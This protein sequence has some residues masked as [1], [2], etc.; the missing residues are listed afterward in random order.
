MNLE[1][2]NIENIY[3]LSPLQQ[4]MLFHTLYAPQSGIYFEQFC[5]PIRGGIN[6]AALAQA[7]QQVINRHSI[8]RTSFFWENIEKPLQVVH[9]QVQLPIEQLDWRNLSPAEQEERLEDYLEAD[10]TKGFELSLAP[11]IRLALIR[12]S[13]DFYQYILS[14]HHL[15]LDGWSGHLVIQEVTAFYQAHCRGETLQLPPEEVYSEQQ[16]SLT[17]ATTTALQSLVRREKLTLNTLLQGAWSL[18]LGRYSGEADVV[19]GAVVSGRPAT[20][21]GIESMVGMFIN[22]LPVRIQISPEASLISW[23]QG[24]QAQQAET[25]KYEYAPLMQVLR[26]S[27]IPGDSTLFESVLVFENY[28]V[29]NSFGE[30]NGTRS[31][32]RV[33]AFERTNLPLS[34]FVSEFEEQLG[35]KLTYDCSRFDAATATRLLGHLRTILEGTATNSTQR[36]AE[37]PLLTTAECQQVLEEW[38]ETAAEYPREVCIHQLFEAR[39]ERRPEAV[40]LVFGEEQ[41]SYAELNRRA[42]QLAHY[43]QQQGVGV[44]TLVGVMVARSVELVVSLL[45]VLKAGA[46]YVPLDPGYPRERLKYMIEDAGIEVVVTQLGLEE[47]LGEQQIKVVRV[48]EQGSELG[49]QSV[50]NVRSGATAENLA[51]VIYTS[52]STGKP[53]GALGTHRAA[54]N[55]FSWMWRTYPF[56]RDEICCQK[57]ST[58]FVDSIWEIFGPLLQGVATVIVPDEVLKDPYELIDELAHRG[59]TRIVLVPSL[60][61]VLLDTG[62]ELHT[63][64]PKLKFWTTSGEALPV[65]LSERFLKSMPERILLNLFGS[66][67]V[68]ADATWHEVRETQSFSSVP[69]GRP[70][71]N[72]QVYIVDAQLQPV[73][74]GVAGRLLIG[75]EGLAR[76][77]LNRSELTAEKFLP[78]PYS[79]VAGGRLYDTGD[80]ARFLGDGNIEFLGRADHQV[81]IRGFRIELGEI[82]ALLRQQAGVQQAVVVAREDAA[83]EKRLWFGMR[84]TLKRLP[85]RTRPLTSSVGIVSTQV[86]PFR[87]T[88]CANG[89]TK[90]LPGCST[91]GRAVC[92]RSDAV[93]ASCYSEFPPGALI[94]AALISRPRRSV[95]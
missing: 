61:R 44:E 74:V 88:R 40:A 64:L 13:E 4:G 73:P 77:Y 11:L 48:A 49:Q 71:F 17:R 62:V 46:A 24:L 14:F 84:H 34:L 57:T 83:G 65:D 6:V 92:W 38:N 63:R 95:I 78:H 94:T 87:Q 76:G 30:Q 16:I 18:L 9:S 75:G 70:I 2:E 12:Q 26:W 81:K 27:E 72:T 23:L 91:S 90:P 35:L 54:L 3:E 22:T 37:L 68:A 33:R 51:Y 42:N 93:R 59:I 85:C 29:A 45:A 52:G 80:L 55:R 31:F 66:S 50:E 58:S 5:T 67:E 86:S 41:V 32:D 53:K 10:R 79:S 47:R 60:L 39:V 25:R 28:P 19:F 7:W 15:L 82:E 36:L 69:I 1:K 56:E 8:L 21:S 43:L 20:L 89:W